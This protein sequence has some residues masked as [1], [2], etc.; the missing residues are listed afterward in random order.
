[1][2][3]GGG[4]LIAGMATGGQGAEARHRIMGVQTSAFPGMF[5]AIKGTQHPQGNSTIAEGIAVGTPGRITQEIIAQ[6]GRPA[7]GG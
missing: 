4:G 5:N 6:G 2:A 1:M 3:V 7:A